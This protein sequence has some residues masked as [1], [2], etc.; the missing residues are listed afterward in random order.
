VP[1]LYRVRLKSGS[2]LQLEMRVDVAHGS[3]L[4]KNSP[5]EA[6]TADDLGEVGALSHIREFDEFL[7]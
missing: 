2:L 1:V 3:W 4:C 5:A 6:L 7:V